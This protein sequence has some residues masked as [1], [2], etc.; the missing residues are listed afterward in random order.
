MCGNEEGTFGVCEVVD[1]GMRSGV[2]LSE[3]AAT[4]RSD[5][6]YELQVQSVKS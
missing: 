1:S 4:L 2:V 3:L 6:T 5:F